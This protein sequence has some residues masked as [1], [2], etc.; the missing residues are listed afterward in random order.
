M[1]ISVGETIVTATSVSNPEVSASCLVKVIPTPVSQIILTPSEVSIEVG[2]KISFNAEVFP[3]GAT[4]KSL[5]WETSSQGVVAIDE[6]GEITAVSIGDAVINVKATDGSSVTQSINVSVVPTPVEEVNLSVQGSTTLK[7]GESVAIV[8]SVYPETATNKNLNWTSSDSSIASVV[9]GVVTAHAK[10]GKVQISAVAHNG[11]EASVEIE[12]VPTPVDTIIVSATS[13]M[14]FV[15]ESMSLSVQILPETATYTDVTWSSSDDSVL[16]VNQEG[17]VFAL[18]QGSAYVIVENIE[19]VRALYEIEVKPILVTS[20]VIPENIELEY[21]AEYELIPEI[22]PEDATNKNLLWYSSNS[23]IAV[24]ADGKIC[25]NGVGSATLTCTTTDGSNVSA[26][27]VVNVVK[28]VTSISLSEHNLELYEGETFKLS[29]EIEPI[30]ASNKSVVWESSNENVVIVDQSGIIEAISEGS[31]EISVNTTVYPFLTD[32]CNVL[33]VKESGI[34]SV[35]IGNTTVLVDGHNIIVKDC[36]DA[37]LYDVS[38]IVI[39]RQKTLNGDIH[40]SVI[41]DG[42]Y[43]VNTGKYSL[44]VLIK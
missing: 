11:I 4:T 39:Y 36:S 41:N 24:F 44:K 19:G 12:V 17:L 28:Y 18:A 21:G 35:T 32:V 1:A 3:D 34:E 10:T 38:G 31:A 43:I 29:A 25:A 6:N 13:N 16:Y 26:Y 9:E 33:V 7:D 27:C 37:I 30:D 22:Y 5:I 15:G 8:A 40:F 42:I 20:V 23:A 14:M 2:E